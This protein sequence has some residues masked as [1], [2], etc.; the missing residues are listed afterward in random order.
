MKN[1]RL[2]ML[3]LATVL[4]AMANATPPPPSAA[5]DVTAP[6][7]LTQA[8]VA[9][10]PKEGYVLVDFEIH[11]RISTIKLSENLSLDNVPLGMSLQLI[12]MKAGTHHWQQINTPYYDLAYVLHVE[13]NDNWS[14]SVQPG[15]VNYIGRLIVGE[16]RGVDD[17][18]IRLV[19][20]SAMLFH[21]FPSQ[22]K[23]LVDRY[24]LIYAG[25]Q[26]DDFLTIYQQKLQALEHHR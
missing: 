5:A 16:H 22:M 6:G 19:N 25:P 8:L 14:Y 1:Y 3:F 10:K 13:D 4:T 7:S 20:R 26:R 17:A 9:L 23:V 15:K 2:A 24:P 12:R 21:Q 11:R 18:N